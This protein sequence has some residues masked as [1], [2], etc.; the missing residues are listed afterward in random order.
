MVSTMEKPP[1][2]H[3]THRQDSKQTTV[4]LPQ[5]GGVV[6]NM[7]YILDNRGD[8]RIRLALTAHVL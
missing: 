8:Q 3:W 6:G 4:L 7:L 2:A 5:G 1:D